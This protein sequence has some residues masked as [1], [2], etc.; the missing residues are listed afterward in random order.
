VKP[1]AQAELAARCRA[2]LRRMPLGAGRPD[3]DKVIR[4]TVLSDRKQASSGRGAV[5]RTR[6]WH[7]G[8]DVY[9]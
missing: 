1:F 5:R 7:R 4:L 3:E 8:R 9:Q 2:L 6:R